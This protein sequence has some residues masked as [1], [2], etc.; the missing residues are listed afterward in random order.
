MRPPIIIPLTSD[1]PRLHQHVLRSPVARRHA[2]TLPIKAAQLPMALQ[3]HERNLATRPAHTLQASRAKHSPKVMP[4]FRTRLPQKVTRQVSKTNVSYE[5]SSKSQAET[6]IT[7]PCQA[8]SRFQPL[9]TTPGHMPI[10]IVLFDCKW[11]FSKVQVTLG[12]ECAHF[13]NSEFPSSHP[14]MP[15][16]YKSS[17]Q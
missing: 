4:A 7:Q 15:G 13:K 2:H 17:H 12:S 14:M 9:Q 10:P 3:H 6:H 5:T 1:T 8:V 16:T 11:H